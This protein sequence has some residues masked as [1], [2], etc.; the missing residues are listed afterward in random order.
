MQAPPFESP[1]VAPWLEQAADVL[2]AP[3]LWLKPDATLI[4][5]N[6][7]AVALLDHGRLL[8][9]EGERVAPE[10]L[11]SAAPFSQ[12]LAAAA[13]EAPGLPRVLPKPVLGCLA[14]LV[15]LRSRALTRVDTVLLVL[16]DD[17][18]LDVEPFAHGHGLS[19]P[20]TRILECLA[21]GLSAGETAQALGL[22][23]NTLRTQV[24]ALRRKSGHASTRSL[25]AELARLPALAPLTHD[26]PDWQRA[27]RIT[28][29]PKR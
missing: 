11:A 13:A 28:A 22:P 7:A 26:A 27:Q 29:G 3:L 1:A 25:L 5:A 12:A 9:R 23:P 19:A 14:A 16:A 10:R 21:R 24:A 4:H 17:S 8:R 20:Q 15:P 18:A 6:A 2:A